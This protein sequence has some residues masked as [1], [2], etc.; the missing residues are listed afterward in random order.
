[1]NS[2]LPVPVMANLPIPGKDPAEEFCASVAS[3]KLCSPWKEVG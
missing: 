1:M 2:S 3:A